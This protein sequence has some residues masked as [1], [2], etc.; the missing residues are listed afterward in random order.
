[1]K[2]LKQILENYVPRQLT[3]LGGNEVEKD[4]TDSDIE[5]LRNELSDIIKRQTKKTTIY[6][7]VFIVLILISA[8]VAIVA[9]IIN[10]QPDT[11]ST[12]VKV[13]GMIANIFTITGVAPL[14]VYGVVRGWIKER[15]NAQTLLKLLDGLKKENLQSVLIV[16]S[17]M[18]KK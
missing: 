3:T 18:L 8:I 16:F 15:D 5:N 2:T 17:T 13:I 14:T 9:Y 12:T 4:L 10:Q 7:A 1:M 11:D 6:F